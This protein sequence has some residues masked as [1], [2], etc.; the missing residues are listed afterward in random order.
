MPS[1]TRQRLAQIIL[2]AVAQIIL[3]AVAEQD[4]VFVEEKHQV[5]RC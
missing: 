1:G 3:P 4:F 2:P 5:V